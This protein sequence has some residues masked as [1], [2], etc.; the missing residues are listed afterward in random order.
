MPRSPQ[1]SCFGS[2]PAAGTRASPAG[3]D[4]GRLCPLLAGRLALTPRRGGQ[5]SLSAQLP[6]APQ[7]ELHRSSRA[8]LPMSWSLLLRVGSQLGRK[9]PQARGQARPT[10]LPV[11]QPGLLLCPFRLAVS[12]N[13]PRRPSR[14]LRTFPCPAPSL[15]LEARVPPT[16]H[17][18]A[19]RLAGPLLTSSA[20]RGSAGRGSARREGLRYRARSLHSREH[21]ATPSARNSAPRASPPHAPGSSRQPSARPS[22][23]PRS[24]APRAS[25]EHLLPLC[26]PLI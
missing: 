16:P 22:P 8:L 2:A 5:V 10:L 13:S 15:W 4:T 3:V 20:S 9:V 25:P 1:S 7:E 14:L 11:S 17:P 12:P 21:P 26:A 24:P 23:A 6:P 19:L 18:C